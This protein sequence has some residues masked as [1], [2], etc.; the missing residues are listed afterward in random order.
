MTPTKYVQLWNTAHTVGGKF[1]VLSQS[2]SKASERVINVET[3]IG[4]GED[5]FTSSRKVQRY[6][7]G[8]AKLRASASFTGEMTSAIFTSLLEATSPSDIVLH[9]TDHDGSTVYRVLPIMRHEPTLI[10]ISA[11]GSNAI[12]YAKFSFR[13]LGVVTP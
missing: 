12:Y 5:D 2:F 10:T 4:P 9:Y 3:T 6:I 1:V 13:V 7:E 8:V 11:T